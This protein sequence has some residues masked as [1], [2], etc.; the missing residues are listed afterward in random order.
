MPNLGR[1]KSMLSE[2]LRTRR[3]PFLL[4]ALLLYSFV[5]QPNAH[6]AAPAQAE[7]TLSTREDNRVIRDL[8]LELLWVT[9]GAFA[10]GTV[11]GGYDSERPVTQVSITKGYWLGKTEV[12]QGQWWALMGTRPAK[13]ADDKRP[14]EQVSWHEGMA[15]CAKLTERERTAGRLPA[16]FA[17]TLPTEAQWEYA[18]RAGTTG[19]YAGDL[20]AL[21]WYDKNS[22]AETHLVGKK[23]PNAW[24]FF[25]MHGNVW[26]WCL[27]WDANY[28]GD[29][30]SD[31]QGEPVGLYRISRGGSWSTSAIHCR[32]ALRRGSEPNYRRVNLGFRLALCVVAK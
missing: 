14:V 32:S 31:P 7:Q 21:G 9:P 10:M 22:L 3:L 8:A 11:A 18:C 16:G 28:L 25:D 26:E 5:N 30:S 12:T 2:S 17:Y 23:Q 19:D 4:T 13:F 24:G 1:F 20:D 29:S 15:F 6:C 27:D